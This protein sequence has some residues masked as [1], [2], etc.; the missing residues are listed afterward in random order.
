MTVSVGETFPAQ[1]PS[2]RLKEFTKLTFCS[3]LTSDFFIVSYQMSRTSNSKPTQT[4]LKA[5]LHLVFFPVLN[6]FHK[7]LKTQTLLFLLKQYTL[8]K[9]IHNHNL[10]LLST[11]GKVSQLLLGIERFFLFS[12]W[13]RI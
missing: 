8:I 6:I 1:K 3:I 11:I 4:N 2:V 10:C 13:G 7:C 5:K 12:N 9:K